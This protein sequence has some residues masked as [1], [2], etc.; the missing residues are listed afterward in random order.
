MDMRKHEVFKNQMAVEYFAY[1][2]EEF[3]Q[4]CLYVMQNDV[5]DILENYYDPELIEDVCCEKIEMLWFDRKIYFSDGS[6][7]N[8]DYLIIELSDEAVEDLRECEEAREDIL[9]WNLLA[10]LD[11][12][13]FF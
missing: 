11:S 9:L 7:N 1:T 8:A 10:A 2:L 13:D 3:K 12:G 4:K 6:C 5:Y